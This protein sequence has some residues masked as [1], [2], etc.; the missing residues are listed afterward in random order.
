MEEVVRDRM[1]DGRE[2]IDGVESA[3]AAWNISRKKEKVG[4]W[5]I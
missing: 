3:E 4:F 5:K 2:A 1:P